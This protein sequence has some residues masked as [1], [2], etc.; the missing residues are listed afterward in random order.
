VTVKVYANVPSVSLTLNG[1]NLG[2]APVV[3]HVATWPVTL[4]PGVNRLA[5]EGGGARDAV[6]WTLVGK[7]QGSD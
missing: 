6:T 7:P 2:S 3:D 1:R 5:V 4:A